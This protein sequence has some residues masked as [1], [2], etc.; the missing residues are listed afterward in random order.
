MAQ[1]RKSIVVSIL[2]IKDAGTAARRDARTDFKSGKGDEV[3]PLDHAIHVDKRRAG[4]GRDV[5]LPK[6]LPTN[7]VSYCYPT[8]GD[9]DCE[10]MSFGG[11]IFDFSAINSNYRTQ[12]VSSVVSSRLGFRTQNGDNNGTWNPWCEIFHT[13]K[14][15]TPDQVGT[16]SKKQIDDKSFLRV[17]DTRASA[18]KPGDYDPNTVNCHFT[19]QDTPTPAWHSGITVKGWS[20]EYGMWQLV[21]PNNQ[22][23]GENKLYFRSSLNTETWRDW[24]RVFTTSDT[25]NASDVGLGLV[26]NTEHTTTNKANTV[27]VRDGSG[28]LHCRLLRSEYHDQTNFGGGIAYR[29]NN[30]SDNYIRFCTNPAAV[31]SW[32]GLDVGNGPT[33]AGLQVNNSTLT[34]NNDGRKHLRF[35]ENGAT[36]GYLWKDPGASWILNHGD[37]ASS[38]LEWSPNGELVVDGARWAAS[39]AHSYANQPGIRAPI[40][41]NFGSVGGVSDYYPL[42]RGVS[43][44][45]GYGFRCQVDFGHLRSGNG[46]WDS[47]ISA[48]IRVASDESSSHPSAIFSFYQNG[49]LNGPRN[50]N[51][52]DVYIRSD[53]RLK[54]NFKRIGNASKRLMGLVPCFYDK[55]RSLNDSTIIKREAGIIAQSLYKNLPEG[56]QEIND[57]D[58]NK[59]L[60][61]SSSAINGLVVAYLQ[62]LNE[63]VKKELNEIRSSVG[64]ASKDIFAWE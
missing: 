47:Q 17:A 57:A 32:L 3:L 13:G 61:V 21:S 48:V 11:T 40:Q 36:D 37:K 5:P 15:P 16:Y 59:V 42:L 50:G 23:G 1:R 52:N 38:K 9:P 31:R 27:A 22:G 20:H 55:K 29:I 63:G 43:G 46:G 7:A 62:D 30:S 34:I 44:A 51:F 35:A 18:M 45:N 6:D 54:D 53:I 24:A 10:G 2:D 8:V 58:G 19:N 25:P 60:G 56:I 12:I 41:V 26:P 33:F 4:N 28:D 14:A 49:D 39:H 64:L